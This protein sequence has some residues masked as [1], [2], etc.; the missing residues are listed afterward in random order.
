MTVKSDFWNNVC[1]QRFP[2]NGE[3]LLMQHFVKCEIRN[4]Q[5]FSLAFGF[6]SI[7]NESLETG[8]RNFVRT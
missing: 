1:G 4:W 8:I 3:F 2:K 7:T 5:T 6:I